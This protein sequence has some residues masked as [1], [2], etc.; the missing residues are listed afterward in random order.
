LLSSPRPTI[1]L[2]HCSTAAR[3]TSKNMWNGSG[4]VRRTRSRR[5]AVVWSVDRFISSPFGWRTLQSPLVAKID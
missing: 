1:A 5:I 4:S 2:Q 3:I